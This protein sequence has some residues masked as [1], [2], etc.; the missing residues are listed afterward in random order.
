MIE[1][2]FKKYVLTK[3]YS[4]LKLLFNVKSILFLKYI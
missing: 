2:Y 3:R 1:G 4:I